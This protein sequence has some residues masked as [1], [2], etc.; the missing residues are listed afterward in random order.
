MTLTI[1]YEI[2]NHKIQGT[3]ENVMITNITLHIGI[4]YVLRIYFSAIKLTIDNFKMSNKSSSSNVNII[5]KIKLKLN[6]K[7]KTL[8]HNACAQGNI[9]AV[10]IYI[11]HGAQINKIYGLNM[12]LLMTTLKFGTTNQI[13]TCTEL[14]KHDKIDVNIK[15]TKGNTA[16]MYASKFGKIMI[17]ELIKHGADVNAKNIYGYTALIFA[18]IH[19]QLDA[20]LELMRCGADINVTNKFEQTIFDLKIIKK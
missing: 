10:H 14:I 18:V 7:L 16:L 8:L 12:T 3:I 4:S 9:N 6:N 17:V 15:D 19:N 1:H 11:A 13:E 5:Y 2:T 20:V